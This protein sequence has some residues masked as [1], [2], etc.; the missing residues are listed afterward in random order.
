MIKCPDCGFELDP[1]GD[2]LCRYWEGESEELDEI[3]RNYTV[4]C[5]NCS[6]E[7]C[8]DNVY[9]Y[10]RTEVLSRAKLGIT[11]YYGKI[12]KCS[13]CGLDLTDIYRDW[14]YD[15]NIYE[16]EVHLHRYENCPECGTE[17]DV[18]EFYKCDY[19]DVY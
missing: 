2:E 17:V 13:K 7:I 5:P 16:N 12:V 1:R 9:N 14:D 6:K 3:R 18:D 8:F 11:Y 15:L 4:P 10:N 19:I